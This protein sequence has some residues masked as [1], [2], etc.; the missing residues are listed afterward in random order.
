[1]KKKIT[2][3]FAA[4]CVLLPSVP[5]YAAQDAYIN[6]ALNQQ[7]KASSFQEGFDAGLANDGINDNSDYTYWKSAEDDYLPWWQ[8]DLGVAQII[9]GVEIEA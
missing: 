5:V 9:S 6:A 7:A 8:T 2:A 3:F 4:V 1:M